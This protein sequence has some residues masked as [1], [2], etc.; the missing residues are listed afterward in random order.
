VKI[1]GEYVENDTFLQPNGSTSEPSWQDFYTDAQNFEAGKE[2][3]LVYQNTIQA[4]SSLPAVYNHLIKNF[5][6][7]DLGI[8]DQFRVDLWLQDFNSDVKAGTVPGLEE[9]WI[10]CDHTGGP[11]T[12]LAEQ[13]DNDLA[14]GRIIDYISHSNV[15]SSSAIFIEEDDSQDGVD[16]ID[17]HRAP[18]YIV[19]PYTVQGGPTQHTHYTQVNMTRTIEQ[20]LG[21]PPMNQFDLVASPMRTAFVSG[22]PPAANFKPWSHV[23]NQ[24]PLD[25]GVTASLDKP[26]DSPA[27][28]AM[29]AAWLQ[30]KAEIFAGKLTK[31]DS[32]D[33][34]TVNHLNWYMA[35]GFTRPYP[36]E[37]T[38][39]PP[40]DFKNPAPTTADLDDE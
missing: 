23:K 22:M 21:L 37:K 15:W 12:G 5:P 18:G 6:Q 17:G 30:K 3:T 27:V 11:P 25:E 39:R 35:T 19:S 26:T 8:P 36:G 20:I 28:K 32:E 24:I 2:K 4:E 34:D 38:V 33:P 9:L 40:S 13:A 31:P 29:R 14:V 16:H 10:M 7:F 1:Y